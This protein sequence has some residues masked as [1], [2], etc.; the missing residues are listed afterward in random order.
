MLGS[1]CRFIFFHTHIAK[2]YSIKNYR[3]SLHI[4]MNR[5]H[6]MVKALVDTGNRL[7]EPF[8]GKPVCL[9]EYESLKHCLTGR[10]G[11]YYVRPIPYHSIGKEHGILWGV[12]ADKLIFQ[13]QRRKIKRHGCIIGIYPGKISSMGEY[14]AIIHP[15]ILKSNVCGRSR[16]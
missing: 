15:D 13:N 7:Y 3:G 5:Q 6:I 8:T 12:T 11:H 4:F 9:V 16:I 2:E 14:N 10:D 1:L